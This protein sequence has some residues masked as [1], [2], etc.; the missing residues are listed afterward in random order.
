MRVSANVVSLNI[1]CWTP[2][3][4]G[5][6][7]VKIC[8]CRNEGCSLCCKWERNG[9]G[10][11]MFWSN[12]WRFIMNGFNEPDGCWKNTFVF[13]VI[14]Q[15]LFNF[16]NQIKTGNLNNICQFYGF[17]FAEKLFLLQ[18]KI[19]YHNSFRYKYI[20]LVAT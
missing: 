18:K 12:D 20:S 4:D 15:N 8:G 17:Y 1:V 16:L 7:D 10:F 9:D 2:M 5:D 13:I 19:I 14:S 6:V 11:K 3:S